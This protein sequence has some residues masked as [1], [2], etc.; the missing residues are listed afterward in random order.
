MAKYF[1]SDCWQSVTGV[2]GTVFLADTRGLHK[3]SAVIEGSR[4]IFSLCYSIDSFGYQ[5][6]EKSNHSNINNQQLQQI[7][8]TFPHYLESILN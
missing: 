8:Q 6:G 5:A 4:S 1:K 3:G 7:H 2:S